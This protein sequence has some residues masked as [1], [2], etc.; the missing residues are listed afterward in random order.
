MTAGIQAE[1]RDGSVSYVSE[2]GSR[3]FI[4]VGRRCSDLW[5]S[6][7]EENLAFIAVD[8][9]RGSDAESGP[10]ILASTIYVARRSEGFVP[11]RL[12]IKPVRLYD[13]DW[14]VLRAPR[15]LPDGETVVFVVPHSITSGALFA[16]DLKTAITREVADGVVAFCIAWG[17]P[18]VGTI[19]TQRRRIIDLQPRYQCYA[20]D[21]SGSE[22]RIAEECELFDDF[23][24][25][26]SQAEGGSCH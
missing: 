6:P 19:L 20:K 15:V 13:R 8:R 14:Q 26:W 17:G 12:E 3:K 9:T 1:L 2:D 4:D 7:D 16:H 18:R 23:S 25:T 10:L 11:V 24:R 5:V 22:V 21:P